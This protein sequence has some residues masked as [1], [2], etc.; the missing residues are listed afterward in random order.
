MRKR[1]LLLLAVVL[2]VVWP[3]AGQVPATAAGA[4]PNGLRG[5]YYLA[6]AAGK[7]DFGQLK[8][9]MVDSQIDMGDLNPVFTAVTGRED[10]VTVR[11]TGKITPAHS[12]TYTFSMIGDNGFRLW[13]DGKLVIDHWVDDWDKEQVGTPIA[14][15]AGKAYDFKLE[16]FEHF[17]GANLHLSWQSPSQPKAVVPAEAFTL[18]D[19]F[20]PGPGTAAVN[21]AGDTL[22]LD[23]GDTALAPLPAGVQEHF[24]VTVA[25]TK[26]PVSSAAL[27]GNTKIELKLGHPVPKL[28][29]NTIRVSYDGQGGITK[30]DGSALAAFSYHPAANGSTYVLKTRWSGDVDADNPLP[31]Y[32]RPQLVRDRWQNLNGTWQFA[33]AKEGETP[34][35]GRDLGEKIVVPYPVESSLSGIGRHED[36]M[37]YRRTFTVPPS[38]SGDRV[39]LHLDAVDYESVVYVNGK[40]VG[41]HKGGFDRITVDVTDALKRG[42]TQELV[43]GVSDPTGAGGQPKGKQSL[44]PGGIWYTPAS[45]I[46]QTV[47]MEPVGK[48]YI[49]A[50]DTIPEV[51]GQSLRVKV[52]ASG[53]ATAVVT[54]RAGKRVVGKVSGP[55]GKELAVPIPDPHLWTPDD[56]YLYDLTVE[57]RGGDRVES[58]FGMRSVSIGRVNGKTRVM[59]NGKPV[60]QF[61]PLDQGYW[62]DGIYTAPTDEAL[63]YDLEQT[64]AL[65]FNMV[66][67]H[68]K[69]ESD[70]WYAYADKLGLLVWQDMPSAVGSPTA[71]DKQQFESEM[72]E[73]VDEHRSS[74]SIVMW[75][76]FNES[77]GQYDVSRIADY[78]KSLDPSRLVD[79]MSGINCC[80]SQDGGNGDVMD[81]HIY[82]GPGTPGQPGFFR[83]SVLGEYGGLGLP[84]VGH[85]WTGGGWGYAVESDSEALTKRFLE[86][87]DALRKLHACSG[88]SAAVYTQT[89]DVETELNGLMTYDRAVMKPDVKRVHDANTVLT[90]E[91][92]PACS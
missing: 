34:P 4:A 35:F 31:E 43:V 79:N 28:S 84:L 54:A 2:G 83:A 70:R 49:E 65:G 92:L 71:A 50:V 29:G 19:G 56:P 10:D 13:V 22:T 80:G 77:W 1:I 41:T 72:R 89:T 30:A 53:D 42:G 82:P 86:M 88:L 68:M 27:A 37:W 75:V 51:L 59:L 76:P 21:A 20:D 46:W 23:F 24:V 90:G 47:W 15:E 57:L 63:R 45:G 61:G 36:R 6:S 55:A 69:V 16:Y 85:T 81:Y 39:L 62:P 52:R 67:K 74:P 5:D 18:P 91:I 44:A 12:E 38:W 11:W 17:G 87:D 33:A 64:K 66:R 48:T 3:V 9:T 58:Y 32:P 8:A 78:V 73:M 26:W 60:F 7:F 25:W 40:Q 14:L